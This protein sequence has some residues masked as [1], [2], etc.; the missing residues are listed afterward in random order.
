MRHGTAVASGGE[1]GGLA[2]LGF[3]GAGEPRRARFGG[4]VVPLNGGAWAVGLAE[5]GE[6][7]VAWRREKLLGVVVVE[8][9]YLVTDLVFE[10]V[11]RDVITELELE[12]LLRYGGAAGFV[13]GVVR[14]AA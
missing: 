8:A 10:L 3:V 2:G 5:R 4:G 6:W 1:A 7:H 13:V 9:S 11:D 14:R 12:G